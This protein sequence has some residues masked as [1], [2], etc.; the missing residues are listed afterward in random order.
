MG[1]LDGVPVGIKDLM[2]TKGWP[3]L[4]GS[5]TID[6]DQPWTDDAPAVA[7]LREHGAVLLGK[8]TTPE[9]GWKGVTDSPLTGI[10]R[11]PWNLDRT[12]GGSSGGA[13][14]ALAA[15][16]C[17]LATGT[18]GGGSIR[19]PASFAGVAG[20][21]PSFGRVPAWPS[22]PFG[23]VAHV[24][25]MART[26]AD[27]ALML[28]VMAEP[29]PRDWFALPA[30][31]RD[32]TVGLDDGVAGLRI[33]WSVDLGYAPVDAEVA[34][35]TERAVQ[36]FAELGAWVDPASPGFEDPAPIFRTHWYA[37]AA[38]AIGDFSAEKMALVEPALARVVEEGLRI[39][40]VDYL[41]A[42]QARAALGA[43]MRAFHQDWDLLV[44]P[45]IAVPP[46]E[47]GRLTPAS[48]AGVDW[49]DDWTTWTPFTYPFNLTQQ[50]AASV[51]CGFTADGLPV[52]LQIVGPM[53]A[54]ALVLRAA[55]AF[56]A[57]TDWHMRRAPIGE[58]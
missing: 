20:L 33:A 23:T 13:S 19:I 47:A 26:I 34:A 4:R 10:T 49:R 36:V 32:F 6:P 51:P 9:Y 27:C 5:R 11:N 35:I 29:D 8:T 16:F 7:R 50:P 40:L 37:G 15:G 31:A 14:A 1:R 44:T 25:P 48:T 24:G 30:E 21:K 17:P 53:H 52:G 58:A 55:R 2:L 56:E 28:Q 45:T 46:F 39:G 22:S 18:D 42:T 57:A 38:A 3:T 54:D 12:P 43:R 41:K